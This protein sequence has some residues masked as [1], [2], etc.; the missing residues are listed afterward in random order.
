M[1]TFNFDSSKVTAGTPNIGITATDSTAFYN[2]VFPSSIEYS[3]PITVKTPARPNFVIGGNAVPLSPNKLPPIVEP[4]PGQD[5]ASAGLSGGYA[6]PTL[7]DDPLPD[8]PAAELDVDSIVA[9][10]DPQISITLQPFIDLPPD[11]LA[12]APP[13]IINVDSSVPGTY[14]T[15]FQ[16]NYSDEQDLAGAAAPGSEQAYFGV[17]A[18]VSGTGDSATT[19]VYID[20]PEPAPMGMVVVAVGAALMCRRRDRID[21]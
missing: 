19:S 14:F 18:I 2:G 4:N 20:V 13:D 11:D 3:G 15:Q 5:T 16:L 6:A 8:E 7:I 10:G 17:L 12:D 1:V 21:D 9:I